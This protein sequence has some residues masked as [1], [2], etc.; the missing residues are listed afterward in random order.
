MPCTAELL[1]GSG[2]ICAGLTHGDEGYCR[3]AWM[4][5]VFAIPA[6]TIAP[7]GLTSIPIEV[8][9]LATVDIDAVVSLDIDHPHAEDLLITLVNVATSEGTVWS[10]SSSVT[11]P[12]HLVV[13]V[14][15]FPGDEYI[16]GEWTL[17]IYNEGPDA[18]SF[19]GGSLEL[20]SRYD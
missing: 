8:S 10:S 6:S 4:H 20:T 15:G 14:Y 13:P 3:P 18:G 9:G 16:N 19:V 7:S 17:Q 1:C 11:P 12:G 2:L 5:G